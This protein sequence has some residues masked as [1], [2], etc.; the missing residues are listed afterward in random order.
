MTCIGF[1][2]EK[3]IR[4]GD[5]KLSLFEEMLKILNNLCPKIVD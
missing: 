4:I 5:H 1:F 2:G 3:S